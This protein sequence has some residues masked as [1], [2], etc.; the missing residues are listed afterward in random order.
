VI[1]KTRPTRA[2]NN[3]AADADDSFDQGGFG[4]IRCGVGNSEDELDFYPDES[5]IWLTLNC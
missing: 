4:K 1:S 5:V 2:V 3:G